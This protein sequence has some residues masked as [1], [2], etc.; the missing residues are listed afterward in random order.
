MQTLLKSIT[1]NA[2]GS[3]T[4]RI[5]PNFQTSFKTSNH[6]LNEKYRISVKPA[7]L[8]EEKHQA[9]PVPDLIQANI[10]KKL[11]YRVK[12][13]EEF[14]QTEEKYMNIL[15]DIINTVIVPCRELKYLDEEQEKAIFSNIETIAKFSDKILTSLK[16][17]YSE[18]FDPQK[19][20]FAHVIVQMQPFFR[21]Y[22]P[23]C[24]NYPDA[25]TIIEKIRK[26][27]QQF[28]L[29]L[30]NIELSKWDKTLDSMLIEPVQRLPRCVLLMK[31]LRKNTPQ[32]HPDYKNIEKAL[33][34]FEELNNT[35]N[36]HMKEYL[37]AMKLFELSEK[38]RK[39][40]QHDLVDPKRKFLLEEALTLI[41]DGTTKQVICYFLS[42][43]LLVTEKIFTEYRLIKYLHFSVMSSV[44][45]I[46]NT[47]H[48]QHL[49]TIYGEEEG[50]TFILDSVESKKNMIQ[51]IN[52][53]IFK[54]LKA[55]QV[56]SL[57]SLASHNMM[58]ISVEGNDEL[59]GTP[60]PLINVNILG[61]LKQGLRNSHHLL[62]I[63]FESNMGN[64]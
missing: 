38:Y 59:Q 41:N 54:E 52:K 55:R 34:T 14:I 26:D 62:F 37:N 11:K 16:S 31:E 2:E 8:E 60:P 23:Y 13:I 33:S 10:E 45:D 63:S 4:A 1:E 49:I 25:R 44:Y 21:F 58:M 42:D 43:M 29:W 20:L 6:V 40:F 47:K 12:N 64:F 57:R 19:T 17:A 18:N 50:L 24:I 32:T 56:M 61:T 15:F 3:P 5:E 46:P 27:N 35:L 53:N 7:H 36:N 30:K 51:F 28:H 9:S 22:N 39:H 48:Y